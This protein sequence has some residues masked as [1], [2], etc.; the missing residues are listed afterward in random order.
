MTITAHGR[1][2]A[3]ISSIANMTHDVLARQ[4]TGRS[5]GDNR[6]C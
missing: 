6:L 3:I 2:V 5:I 4:K 1:K